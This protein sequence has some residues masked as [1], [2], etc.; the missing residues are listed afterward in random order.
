MNARMLLPLFLA[1]ASLAFA[2][3]AKPKAPA[4]AKAATKPPY[5][6]V[7]NTPLAGWTLAPEIPFEAEVQ[8]TSEDAGAKETKLKLQS[9]INGEFEEQPVNLGEKI[10]FNIKPLEGENH[11]ELRLA[12]MRVS[13]V[14]TFWGKSSQER[15]RIRL[16][17]SRSDEFWYHTPYGWLEVV[18][19]D[20]AA[21]THGSTPSGGQGSWDWFAHAQPPAGT[22]TLRWKFNLDDSDPNAGVTATTADSAAMFG[23]GALA[24]EDGSPASTQDTSM[25]KGLYMGK[26]FVE[27]VLDAGSDH[28][29][30]WVFDRLFLPGR[31]QITLGSFDVTD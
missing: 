2:A 7:I 22:W 31:A 10:N 29:R 19:P 4:P 28:E 13:A 5:R 3:P 9:W 27:V 11:V 8:S 25:G 15:L 12:G 20:G 30:R 6:I 1:T 18:E 24:G 23:D 26:V 14:R 16:V 21:V 17:K